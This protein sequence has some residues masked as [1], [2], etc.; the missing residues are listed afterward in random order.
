MISR[1]GLGISLGLLALLASAYA[2]TEA[3][4]TVKNDKY[5]F[6]F[7]VEKDSIVT[8]REGGTG[9]T[10]VHNS[11]GAVTGSEPDYGLV[12][13][14][15]L[16]LGLTAAEA[17]AAG[18]GDE[19]T[20]LSR[21]Q[22]GSQENLNKLVTTEMSAHERKPAG[23]ATFTKDDGKTAQAPYFVW[24]RTVNSTTH[25]A[26]MYVVLHETGFILV[27]VESSEP[28]SG[29]RLAWVT[30]KLKLNKSPQPAPPEDS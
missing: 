15:Q 1:L 25:Y 24:E 21:A 23:T 26:L 30:S 17:K 29:D 27:Q 20:E 6:E 28:L 19:A 12:V 11:G 7:T 10:C 8:Y 2:Q 16:M 3:P 5:S 18:L 13:H 14:G 9:F 4:V 22:V